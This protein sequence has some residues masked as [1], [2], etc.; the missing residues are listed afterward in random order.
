MFKD[1]NNIGV[2]L[3]TLT[4]EELKPVRDEVQQIQ[5]NF[6]AA[7]PFTNYLVGHI[8]HEYM[9]SDKTTAYIDKLI[10][11]FVLEYENHYNI[12]KGID[13][14]SDPLPMAI[15]P[16]WVNFMKKHEYN[17]IHKHSGVFS[18]VIWLEIPFS[19]EDEKNSIYSKNSRYPLPGCFQLIYTNALGQI[20]DHY[21]PVDKTFRNKIIIFPAKLN[22]VVYPFSTS[23]DFRISIAGNYCLKV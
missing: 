2:S 15:E 17:P 1:F 3:L 11:P 10:Q 20:S 7:Q 21:I 23:D 8:E 9:L 18:F 6:T 22:H 5:N 13:V 12:L 4:D 16:V 14:L 19:W